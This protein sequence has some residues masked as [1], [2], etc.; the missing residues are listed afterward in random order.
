MCKLGGQMKLAS[1]MLKC[2]GLPYQHI[3]YHISILHTISAAGST[4]LNNK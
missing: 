4:A 3:T 2:P 1:D